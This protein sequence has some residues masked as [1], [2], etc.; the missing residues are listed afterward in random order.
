[1]QF[2]C[3]GKDRQIIYGEDVGV[4]LNV[5]LQLLS[6]QDMRTVHGSHIS[7]KQV[8]Q[9]HESSFSYNTQESFPTIL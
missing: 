5:M 6:G 8:R 1:M 4:A 9:P 3:F 2:K 7:Y